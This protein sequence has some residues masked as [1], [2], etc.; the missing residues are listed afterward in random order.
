MNASN[1]QI[2]GDHYRAMG[3]FQPWDVL[4]HWLTPEEYRG[5]NKGV[6]IAYLARERAKGGDQDIAKAAHHLQ[7]LLEVL[8]ESEPV[9]K[10]PEPAP[11]HTPARDCAIDLV[12]IDPNWR[13]WEGSDDDSAPAFGNVAVMFRDGTIDSKMNAESASWRHMGLDD[14]I[15]KWKPV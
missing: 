1:T 14:D 4:Q 6:A 15:V 3:E 9:E 2:G 11:Q 10:A 12:N 7:K 13:E 5:Y 8:Q